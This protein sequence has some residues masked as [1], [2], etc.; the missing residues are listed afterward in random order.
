MKPHNQGEINANKAI[1]ATAEILGGRERRDMARYRASGRLNVSVRGG[2]ARFANPPTSTGW[3]PSD[4][5]N[6]TE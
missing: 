5:D 6:E 1:L 4:E 2:I 3:S